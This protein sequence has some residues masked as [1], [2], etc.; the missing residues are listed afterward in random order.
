[1]A[2]LSKVLL[3]VRGMYISS[4]RQL[5]RSFMYSGGFSTATMAALDIGDHP[6]AWS[7]LLDGPTKCAGPL[8]SRHRYN[9]FD[10]SCAT[11]TITSAVVFTAAVTAIHHLNRDNPHQDRFLFAGLVLGCG[12]G[13]SLSE[14]LEH[15]I[16]KVLPWAIMMGLLCSIALR[17]VCGHKHGAE[18][19]NENC[20]RHGCYSTGHHSFEC[21]ENGC[22]NCDNRVC[23]KCG[24]LDDHGNVDTTEVV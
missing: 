6:G 3:Y 15:T 11:H 1:M 17:G 8:T 14:G 12:I 18:C 4:S 23:E 16:L 13:M 24:L 10:A 21:H 2:V 9:E 7:H 20:R 5:G 19:E 22:C